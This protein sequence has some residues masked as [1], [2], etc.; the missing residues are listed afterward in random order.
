MTADTL[1][2]VGTVA[3]T[4]AGVGAVA[5]ALALDAAVGEPPRRLHPVAWF[6]R[7]VGPFDA[8]WSRPDV[9]G[10]C[11]SAVLP[12]AAAI[13]VGTAVLAAGRAGL[14]A[15]VAVASLGLFVSTSLRRLIERVSDVLASSERDPERARERLRALAGRDAADLTPGQIRSA[16]VESLAE[17]LADGLVAPL[18]G[19]AVLA[20]AAFL[21]GTGP[22]V[23]LAAG[24]AGA[25]WV[26]AVNT[27][28]SMLGYRGKPV[29]RIPARVDDAVMWLPARA[30]AL[31]LAAVARSPAALR[32]ARPW[33]GGVSSP[34]SGWPMGTLAAS[35]GCRLE[36]PGAYVLNPA[37]S[38]PDV[39][40]GQVAVRQVVVAGLLAY[41]LTG[42]AVGVAAWS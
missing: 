6:G 13:V 15:A 17:N 37:A 11:V 12:A 5:G 30:S 23:A 40:T 19:F 9:V 39:E 1:T 25:A 35:L 16:A 41:A 27:L 7:A 28:D 20:A 26:K 21:A 42:A 22:V 24:T 18:S 33:T 38:L 3:D 10:A 34:N 2:A 14:A 8:D 4:L 32:T 36:K 31:L 29:G